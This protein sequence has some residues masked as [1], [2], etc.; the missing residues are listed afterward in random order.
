M[1]INKPEIIINSEFISYKKIGNSNLGM[2]RL[3]DCF[4]QYLYGPDSMKIQCTADDDNIQL[5]EGM[6]I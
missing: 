6:T 5:Y 1:N 2:L 3:D 4:E